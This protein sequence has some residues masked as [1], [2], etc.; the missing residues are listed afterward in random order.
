MRRVYCCP[1]LATLKTCEICGN[2]YGRFHRIRT[3]LT[4]FRMCDVAAISC[5]LLRDRNVRTRW[6]I[7]S[8]RY[9]HALLI[10]D[11]RFPS[12]Q[13]LS[14]LLYSVR[15]RRCPVYIFTLSSHVVVSGLSC[16]THLRV[17]RHV[18]LYF[19]RT[20][21]AFHC[22][23]ACTISVV[24]VLSRA[25]PITYI[26]RV[27]MLRVAAKGRARYVYI[28]RFVYNVWQLFFVI[29]WAFLWYV[30]NCSLC[31]TTNV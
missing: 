28:D 5:M 29:F 13:S 20:M 31:V 8:F 7:N 9:N 19:A 4:I 2:T 3:Y 22:V 1:L 24:I 6:F 16:W 27:S 21:H 23:R 17:S 26:S 12:F 18:T 10:F 15:L 14:L 25:Y 30:C 11:F